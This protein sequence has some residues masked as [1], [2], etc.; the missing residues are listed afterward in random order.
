MLVALVPLAGSIMLTRAAD[1]REAIPE[2]PQPS[3]DAPPKP[4]TTG[5]LPLV[6]RTRFLLVVA[7]IT[8]LLNWVN[9]NGENLLFRVVQEMLARDLEGLG[10]TGE[11]EVVSYLRDAT[12]VFY[13][14]FFFWVNLVALLLQALL[15]SR[16]L[17]YGGFGAI[18]L[19]L[20]GIAVISYSAMALVPILVV[21]KWMKVAENATDYSINN[22]ARHV[23]WLPMSREVTFKAKP[24]IDSLFVRAGDG[25]AALT[26][27]FGVR[28]FTFPLE[29]YMLVNIALVAAWLIAAVWVVRRHAELSESDTA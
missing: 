13:G 2:E 15:A 11:E 10:I 12:T 16:L 9:T 25:L 7:V 18:F 24:T 6:F 27:L 14:S 5:A 28:V 21:V 3:E 23:L 4:P 26:V 22:T 8:L 19:L 29:A 1:R 20:P 17:K